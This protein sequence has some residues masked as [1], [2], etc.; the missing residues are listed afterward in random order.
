MTIS[1]RERTFE[2][3]L[4]RA[5]GAKREQVRN[6]FIGES[7]LL[8][9]IGGLGG[10][11]IGFT[12]VEGVTMV[13]PSMPLAYSLPYAGA[14]QL[15]SLVIGLIAGVVPAQR[16]AALDPVRALRTE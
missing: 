12:I 6:L 13:V 15:L 7:I 4:L 1:V 11:L 9:G 2:I 5:V 14:A 16:A 10:L 3:G 8:A